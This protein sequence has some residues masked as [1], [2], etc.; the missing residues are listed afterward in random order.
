MSIGQEFK[1]MQRRLSSSSAGAAECKIMV[2]ESPLVV[3]ARRGCCMSFVVRRL[4]QSVGANPDVCEVEERHVDELARHL[5]ESGGGVLMQFPAVFVGGRWFGGIERVIATLIREEL[6]P[7]L[8][9]AGGL[10]L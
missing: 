6:R 8:K 3:V 9:Q 4:L 10:W 1:N 2:E 5:G 7:L